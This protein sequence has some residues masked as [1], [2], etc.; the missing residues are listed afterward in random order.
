MFVPA[1]AAP[2]TEY[3][4]CSSTPCYH[5][6]TCLDMPGGA[7][8]CICPNSYTGQYCQDEIFLKRYEIPSFNG[9][10]FVRM[11]P[12]KAYHK[13]SIEIEFKTYA[14]DG[15]ILYNQQR[16]D[17]LGDF[18]SL[19]I[20]NGYIEF[21]YN[22]GNGPIIITSLN[23]VHLNQ[24]HRVIIKRYHRDGMLKLDEGED[25][26]GQSGGSL[27]ALDLAEDAFIGYFP[28]NKS[29][30]I[31]KSI[32]YQ[33]FNPRFLR[34]FENIGTNLGFQGCIKKLRIGR[35]T[36][37]LHEKR[38]EW[39]IQTEKIQE[40]DDNPCSSIPCQN[41]GVCKVIDEETY[42]C[43]CGEYYTGEF[44][45][46]FIDPCL[47]NPCGIGATCSSFSNGKYYC[48]CS[49]GHAGSDCEDGELFRWK[50]SLK[51]NLFFLFPTG[52]IDVSIPAFNGS[53]LLEYP[54][55]KEVGKSFKIEIAFLA[56]SLNGLIL[57][58]GQFKNGKGDFISLNLVRGYVQFRFNLGSGIANIT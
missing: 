32:V 27:K 15:I 44:C 47:T 49:N 14:N 4:P 42:R 24:F 51:T 8:S 31:N 13:L 34:V 17:G 52:G 20:V 40:C 30:Y 16:A 25:I 50:F 21:R 11:K 22:L 2:T 6:S 38:D 9:Q 46:N 28:L 36:I 29:R 37:E 23:K 3:K 53:T 41:G 1:D 43:E 56:R 5:S 39:I 48:V 19:A 33:W 35:R 45:Q 18:V 7:F 58:C 55:L 12:L 57:Y 54:P 26:A 10:S